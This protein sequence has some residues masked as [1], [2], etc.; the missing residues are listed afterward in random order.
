[1][2]NQY[3]VYSLAEHFTFKFLD[4]T[5]L[6]LFQHMCVDLMCVQRLYIDFSLLLVNT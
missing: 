2:I 5:I 4:A 6:K 3:I 1:M